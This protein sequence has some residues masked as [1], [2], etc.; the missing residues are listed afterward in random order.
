[1][2]RGTDELNGVYRYSGSPTFPNQ[3]YQS[4]NYW[5]DVVFSTRNPLKTTATSVA[6]STKTMELQSSDIKPRGVLK[7]YSNPFSEKAFI[8]FVH[9]DGGEYLIFLY[10]GKGSFCGPTKKSKSPGRSKKSN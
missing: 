6:P 10:D 7:V 3:N 8:N 4:G 2:Q 1:M 5:V 9:Q